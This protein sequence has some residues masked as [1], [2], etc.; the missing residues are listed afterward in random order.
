VVPLR[1]DANPAASLRAR[2]EYVRELMLDA[3]T[4][5]QLPLDRMVELFVTR[6]GR[7]LTP[8]FRVMCN[9]MGNAPDLAL[10]GGARASVVDQFPTGVAKYDLTLHLIDQP[11][12]VLATVEYATELFDAATVRGFLDRYLDTLRAATEDLAGLTARGLSS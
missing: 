12:G 1:I 9:H 7:D 2:V 8:L 3:F 10:A 5:Q 4:Y 11:T 6:R